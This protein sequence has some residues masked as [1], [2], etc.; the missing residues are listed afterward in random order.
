M[1]RI[2]GLIGFGGTW[3]SLHF[4]W[5]RGVWLN[6]LQVSQVAFA[7]LILTQLDLHRCLHML[8]KTG[9]V[10]LCNL[11]ATTILARL[12]SLLAVGAVTHNHGVRIRQ[13]WISLDRWLD[14]VRQAQRWWGRHFL[15]LG[16]RSGKILSLENVYRLLALR[17][18]FRSAFITAILD[19]LHRFSPIEY[20]DGDY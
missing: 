11:H 13:S 17:R 16:S 19:D 9:L 3:V 4:L 5:Q 14:L 18:T 10:G 8:Q 7:V 20:F 12:L 1:L 15:P 2:V 6:L